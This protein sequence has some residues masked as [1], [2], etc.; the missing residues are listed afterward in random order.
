[1]TWPFDSG[2]IKFRIPYSFLVELVD[3]EEITRGRW[4]GANLEMQVGVQTILLKLKMN[5]SDDPSRKQAIAYL[6]HFPVFFLLCLLF[7]GISILNP[8]CSIVE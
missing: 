5:S 6:H 7:V 2:I 4:R 1:M 3:N 8:S